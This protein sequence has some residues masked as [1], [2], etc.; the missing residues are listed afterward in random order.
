M[1]VRALAAALC[2]AAVPAAA[3]E[4]NKASFDCKKAAT[5]VEKAICD[6]SVTAELDVALDEI[7]RASLARRPAERTTLEAAQRQ[8]LAARNARCA[9]GK[10]DQNCL[11]QMYK[12][13]IIALV[14]A[15]RGIGAQGS[16]I[17]GRYDYRQKGEGGEMFLAEMPDGSTLVMIETVNVGHRSPHTCAF[18]GRLSDRRG[19]VLGYRD[20]EASKTCGLEIAVTGNRAVIRETPKDCFEVAQYYCGAHGYMLGN[21]VRK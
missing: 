9:R 14:R 5:P 6:S 7:Y 11:E 10:P 15:D 20:Q 19:D 1:R 8:W 18:S 13:R 16:F 4:G 2:L 12:A 3:Q 21:Y 17:T